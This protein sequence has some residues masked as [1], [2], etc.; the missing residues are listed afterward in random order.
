M[1]RRERKKL[2]TRRNILRSA[3]ELFAIHGFE[4]TTVGDI[5]ERA[6]VAK[7]TVFNYFPHKTSFLLAA[8]R[9]WM[10]RLEED[11]GPVDSWEASA[12]AQLRRVLD[13]L[14]DLCI[15]QRELSRMIIFESMRETYLRMGASGGQDPANGVRLLEGLVRVVLRRG[16]ES[17]EVRTDVADDMAASLVAATAF[18]TLVRWLVKGGSADEMK[19]ALA[20]KLDIIFTGLAP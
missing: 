8:H 3:F 14:A 11:L 6:D 20:A 16:K 15:E 7:G 2:E 13:Y 9:E 5:A 1:G 18:S 19:A 4:G 10:A 17:G 12:V